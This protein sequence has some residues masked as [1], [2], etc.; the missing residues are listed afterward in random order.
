[1]KNKI[2]K[3]FTSLRFA[4]FLLLII[5]LISGI[6]SIIEQDQSLEYYRQ[7]YPTNKPILGF[8]SYKWILALELNHV[9]KSWIF[10]VFILLLGFSLMCCT[11]TQ[12]LPLV[13]IA[14]QC[15]FLRNVLKYNLLGIQTVLQK[16]KDFSEKSLL[17]LGSKSFYTHQQKTVVY[18]S[19][20]IFGKVGP[21]LVHFSLICILLGAISGALGR[22]NS[23]EFLPKGEI[24]H[25][26]NILGTGWLSEFPSYSFRLNDFWIEYKNQKIGQFYSDISILNNLGNEIF[27]KTISVNKPLTFKSIYFYQ[28][29]WNFLGIRIQEQSEQI[30]Q[31]PL[32]LLSET[33]K[34]WA[35]CIFNE[36]GLDGRIM[37]LDEIKQVIKL[38]DNLGNF[39][40][41]VNFNE[42]FVLDNKTYVIIDL[43]PETGLQVKYDP[44][45]FLTYTGF[46]ALMFSTL[47]SYM[48]YS[49]IWIYLKGNNIF[50]GGNT[51][52]SKSFFEIE[53]QTFL[54]SF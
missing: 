36:T 48:T 37:V 46:A 2:L 27:Q 44:S 31:Y 4:I 22:F 38:Y 21:I 28:I 12:Q 26:Q 39:I 34:I 7:F 40:T 42:T 53:F 24:I 11:F 14:R 29:D 8:L 6:G 50:L 41:L 13:K 32:T 51:T 35:S 19:K 52:R 47:L 15:I 10:L 45:I 49:Q 30:Y 43:I 5:A 20:G 23:Q 25:I 16:S 9:Y 3:L 17:F 54:N 18:A 33:P 1:M